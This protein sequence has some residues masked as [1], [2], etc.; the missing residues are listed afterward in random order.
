[1]MT[2]PTDASADLKKQWRFLRTTGLDNVI[3][4]TMNNN[5]LPMLETDSCYAILS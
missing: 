4:I 3:T 2:Q 1:M 5:K